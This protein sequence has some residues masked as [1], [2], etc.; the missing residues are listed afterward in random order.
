MIRSGCLLI[1]SVL[2]VF[3]NAFAQ[4]CSGSLGDPVVNISF[5]NGTT[6]NVPGYTFNSS[7]CPNDGFYTITS[8]TS[9]CFNASW[10]TIPTD[11]SGGGNFLLVN[12]S[13]TPGDFFVQP[14]T[15]LC[16]NTTYEFA[17]WIMNVHVRNGIKP[18]LS[19]KIEAEDGTVLQEF[20][21]GD[22]LQTS[23]PEWK[24]YGFYFTTPSTNSKIVLRITNNAPGG[25]GNDIALDD[26][27]FR[28]CGAKITATVVGNTDTVNVCEGN[29]DVY[30]FNGTASSAYQSPA[31]Q[32][33]VSAD[34][35]RTW[36]D[37]QGATLPS[38][39]RMP[40]TPGRYL[41]RFAVLEEKDRGLL[42]CRIASNVLAINVHPNPVVSAGPDRV[43][44]AGD[45]II[46]KGK[47]D[48]DRLKYS[49]TPLLFLSNASTLSPTII[50]IQD[51]QYTLVAESAAGCKNQ[52]ETFIKVVADIYIPN[53]FTPN[54]DGK[55]DTWRISFLDPSISAEVT[56]FNRS[57]K[58]VYHTKAA[59]VA[60]DGS[61]TGMAQ[62]TGTYVY[63]VSIPNSS[64]RRKGTVTLIR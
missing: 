1:L 24:Q 50:P 61:I 11:H 22:I 47:A 38:Y 53:A 35:G 62:P 33:Q 31:Y 36:K 17:A 14:V 40:T 49:W 25:I 29:T 42:A 46:L 5:N 7:P 6:A 56:L 19:F 27:T 45:S 34:T 13:Y 3:S 60:W 48:G 12:A 8:S 64:F 20:E 54:G 15:A 2:S 57:G 39:T 10:H 37:I 32:W 58:V 18:N 59:T 44:L 9:G 28:P 43:L 51:I 30:R 41:Y 55:N 21:T 16:A 52:D 63:I 4:L 23:I 26:I